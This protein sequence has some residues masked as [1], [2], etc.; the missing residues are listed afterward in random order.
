MKRFSCISLFIL[1]IVFSFCGYAQ[2]STSAYP[3][4]IAV[5]QNNANPAFIAPYFGYFALPVLGGTNVQLNS[6][7]LSYSSLISRDSDDS[8]RFTPHNFIAGLSTKNQIGLQVNSDLLRLGFSLK[9]HFFHVGASFHQYTTL[10][11][12]KNTLS[13]L[14]LGPGAN[15]GNNDLSGNGGV[16]NS[17]FSLY[18]GWAKELNE[19]WQ[20]GARLKYIGGLYNFTSDYFNMQWDIYDQD[21][22]NP[23]RVPYMYAF[24]V[25]GQ[26]RTNFPLDTGGKIGS[27]GFSP[28]QNNGVG[29]DLG[30]S[31]T[32]SK[33]WSVNASVLDLGSILWKDEGASR[34]ASKNKD[35]VFEFKGLGN[36]NLLGQ[37]GVPFDS[38]VNDVINTLKDTLGFEKESVAYRTWLP[39]QIILGG[40]YTVMEKHL[41]S[42][43]LKFVFNTYKLNP[44]FTLFY[45]YMTTRNFAISVNNKI[46]PSGFVN[47]GFATVFNPGFLQLYLAVEDINSIFVKNMRGV[48][49]AVGVC[50]V[51]GKKEI[52]ESQIKKNR[53]REVLL[54]NQTD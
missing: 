48:N 12:T 4:D 53:R 1:T 28:F 51:F 8:L 52:F 20:V 54:Q 29:V 35:G 36:T 19:Q 21:E 11:L 50:F 17:Y 10:R 3:I 15:V 30:L 44:D 33:E 31:Y 16:F 2:V 6:N 14:A 37:S 43:Q 42:A 27:L 49:L 23:D 26:F 24:K 25:N 5:S 7:F 41:F 9:G 40:T 39:T 22:D 34:W 45:T 18:A 32:I 38:L 46:S 13:F 47:L